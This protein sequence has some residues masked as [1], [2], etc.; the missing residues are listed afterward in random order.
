MALGEMVR[1]DVTM[2]F[3]NFYNGDPVIPKMVTMIDREVLI[4]ECP[5]ESAPATS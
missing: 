2:D 5:A 1:I 3:K 4:L